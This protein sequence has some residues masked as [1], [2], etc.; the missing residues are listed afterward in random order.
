[1]RKVNIGVMGGLI[2]NPNMGCVAL[3]YS[4]ISL[5]EKIS[6]EE[7]VEFSYTIFESSFSGSAINS[8]ANELNLSLDN[9][10][11]VEIGNIGIY[12][13]K[14]SI[15]AI[16]SAK[17]T[18]KMVN[19]I[20]KCSIIFDIT[21]GDS[22]TDLYGLDRFYGL[23]AIKDMV[24]KLGIPLVL[25][26]Q[27]YGPFYRE[28]TKLYAKK[29]IENSKLTIARDEKSV[30]YLNGF[31]DKKIYSV[32]DLAFILPYNTEKSLESKKIKIGINPSGLLSKNKVEGTTLADPINVDYDEYIK[33]LV[34]KLV[35]NPNFEV[36][37][38]PHVGDEAKFS[39]SG[40]KDVIYHDEFKTPIQA[41]SV[42]SQ[43]D[44]FIGARM[45][46][47]I[48]AF[49]SGV[50]TIPTSYSVKF[51]GLFGALGYNRVIDLKNMSTED[52]LEETLSYV[53]NYKEL[54]VEVIG[55]NKVVKEKYELLHRLVKNAIESVL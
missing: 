29:V 54:Q 18:L 17:K 4:L 23:T 7:R 47:T 51:E 35:E 27:T 10:K 28:K 32:T 55:C 2:N 20:K 52:A 16:L 25:A 12:N 53:D 46:A 14:S 33:R 42:I 34:E 40:F 3:S 48:A 21:Q 31:T 1:M 36:H 5:L 43:M 15:K 6:K 24:E 19:E 13:L 50:A 41:K 39:F 22:F 37:L 26:P 11:V 49:S 45:H 9:I 44:V 30:A 8:L 38:I